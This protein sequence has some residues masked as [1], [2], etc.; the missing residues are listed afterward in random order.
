MSS[1]FLFAGVFYGCAL[2]SVNFDYSDGTKR[3]MYS[4][5]FDDPD[6]MS[7]SQIDD[8]CDNNEN[9]DIIEDVASAKNGD[10]KEDMEYKTACNEPKV[11]NADNDNIL[12]ST[13]EKQQEKV[14]ILV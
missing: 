14:C 9:I 1:V 3:V 13:L 8:E 6:D 7:A 11:S 12:K 4:E 10:D 2:H 5:Y